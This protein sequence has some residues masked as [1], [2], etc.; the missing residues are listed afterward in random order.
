VSRCAGK[1]P[2]QHASD[3]TANGYRS[4]L[5]IA[6]GLTERGRGVVKALGLLRDEIVFFER[7]VGMLFSGRE[8]GIRARL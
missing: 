8:A 7:R 5:T 3:T 4:P 1:D 6:G 2:T